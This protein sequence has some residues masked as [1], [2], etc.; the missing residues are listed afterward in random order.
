MFLL[1]VCKALP[2]LALVSAFPILYPRQSPESTGTISNLL[3]QST[4]TSIEKWMNQ[5][6]INGMVIAMTTPKGDEVLT[7]GQ[8][9]KKCTAV[10]DEVCRSFLP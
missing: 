10:M 1:N 9:N 8:A 7:F 3:L 2:L 6:G 5:A 4:T